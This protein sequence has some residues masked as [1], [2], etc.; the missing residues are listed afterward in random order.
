MDVYDKFA[1]CAQTVADALEALVNARIAA[2]AEDATEIP[3][4][5]FGDLEDL[6]IEAQTFADNLRAWAQVRIVR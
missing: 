3:E 4:T 6:A 2:E 1:S 5:P